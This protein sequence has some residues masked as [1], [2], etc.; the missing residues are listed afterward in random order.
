MCSESGQPPGTFVELLTG[1][2]IGYKH[3]VKR[4]CPLS[5]ADEATL[6]TLPPGGH[7]APARPADSGGSNPPRPAPAAPFR[8]TSG[9]WIPSAAS[10][11]SPR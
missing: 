2:S 11:C 6:V 1:T 7:V 9:R 8:R 4:T 10:S 5:A 3:T